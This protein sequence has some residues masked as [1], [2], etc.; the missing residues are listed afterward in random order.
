LIISDNIKRMKRATTVSEIRERALAGE[1]NIPVQN[2]KG[3]TGIVM[4]HQYTA[5]FWRSATV[6]RIKTLIF[7]D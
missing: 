5:E 2:A 6:A 3:K 1:L 7:W 4:A